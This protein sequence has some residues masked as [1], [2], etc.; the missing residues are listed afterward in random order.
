MW[1][2]VQAICCMTASGEEAMIHMEQRNDGT[3]DCAGCE[4]MR[5]YDYGNRI[6][7]CDHED[8]SDDMGKLGVDELPEGS[9]E[10]CPLRE[11]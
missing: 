9:P 10:W 8:R 11:K 3:Q 5:I 7:Y 1:G 6:R 4:F 2:S